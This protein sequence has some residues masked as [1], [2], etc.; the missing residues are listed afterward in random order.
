MGHSVTFD[1]LAYAKKLIAAGVSEKQAEVQAEAL[2]EIVE[3]QLATRKDL[4]EME[5]SLERSIKELELRLKYELTLR[6]GIMLA[7]AIS[8]IA[9]IIKL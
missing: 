5:V 8:I 3:D 7:A 6:M 4:K 9:A 1:T 2:A